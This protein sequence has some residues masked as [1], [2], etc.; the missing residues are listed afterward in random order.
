MGGVMRE[1][2]AIQAHVIEQ[3]WA[4]IDI[5]QSYLVRVICF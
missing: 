3:A 1:R 4:N 2:G 5:L